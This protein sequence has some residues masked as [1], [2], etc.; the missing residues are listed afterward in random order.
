MTMTDRA[1][2]DHRSDIE[3]IV[4]AI[5]GAAR[6]W[7][8]VA[9]NGIPTFL[10]GFRNHDGRETEWRAVFT[11]NESFAPNFATWLAEDGAENLFRALAEGDTSG[12]RELAV[13]L[14]KLDWDWT[15]SD[16]DESQMY[17]RDQQFPPDYSKGSGLVPDW[18]Y[19]RSWTPG[20]IIMLDLSERHSYLKTEYGINREFSRE[21]HVRSLAALS[22]DSS[23]PTGK[24][25]DMMRFYRE[26]DAAW[27]IRRNRVH[28]AKFCAN[29]IPLFSDS[30]ARLRED[31]LE[32]PGQD[33]QKMI[34]GRRTV[35]DLFGAPWVIALAIFGDLPAE[36]GFDALSQDGRLPTNDAE[37]MMR[38]ATELEAQVY[39]DTHGREIQ[40]LSR[41]PE[42]LYCALIH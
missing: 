17:R 33:D 27:Y 36:R 20:W 25:E 16:P 22:R 38:F 13:H 10:F 5:E 39:I 4:C 21:I 24:H 9:V 11:C 35:S 42:P 37:N 40:R 12:A 19:P 18:P 32:H 23:G 15:D 29:P 41:M 2:M 31:C 28:L 8:E 1:G 34:D 14:A 30:V 7:S 3:A 6:S 26:E